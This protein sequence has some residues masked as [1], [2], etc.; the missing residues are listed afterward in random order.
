MY[1]IFLTRNGDPRWDRTIHL[2]EL[3]D[4]LVSGNWSWNRLR[5]VA[6]GNAR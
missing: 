3:V 5:E 4:T 2:F 1:P 6:L